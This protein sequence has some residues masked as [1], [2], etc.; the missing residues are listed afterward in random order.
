MITGFRSVA[1]ILAEPYREHARHALRYAGAEPGPDFKGPVFTSNSK[2]SIQGT[3]LSGAYRVSVGTEGALGIYD[4]VH[5]V[6]PYH[7]ISRIKEIE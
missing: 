2:V 1:I 3:N 4:W 7:T 6:Y 5:Y